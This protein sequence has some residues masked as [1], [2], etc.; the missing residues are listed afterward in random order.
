MTSRFFALIP[1]A[2]TGSRLGD[3]T[4]K[5]YRLLAGKPMLHHAVRSLL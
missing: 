1:A 5:Q 3:E 4:P 2:G